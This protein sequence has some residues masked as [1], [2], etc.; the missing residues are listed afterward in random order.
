MCAP[1]AEILLDLGYETSG[2]NFFKKTFSSW[3][4]LPCSALW[5]SQCDFFF[6]DTETYALHT[7]METITQNRL[8]QNR[9]LPFPA[10]GDL[11][12]LG[13]ESVSLE[14]PALAGRFFTT[15]ATW[16]APSYWKV[17]TWN[18]KT[19][20]IKWLLYLRWH[21]KSRVELSKVIIV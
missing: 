19:V 14:S 21:W 5:E 16:K 7:Y 8:L 20:M 18:R 13:I 2:K 9:L 1:S 11:P 3:E 6:S 17:K 15:S 10:S 4:K 12:N